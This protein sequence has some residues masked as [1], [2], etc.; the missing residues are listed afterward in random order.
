M[1]YANE[2]KSMY[3]NLL[4]D[5]AVD[6]GMSRHQKFDFYYHDMTSL[7]RNI[8]AELVENYNKTYADNRKNKL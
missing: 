5:C 3:D 7:L 4:K 2:C 6:I 1:D 8:S